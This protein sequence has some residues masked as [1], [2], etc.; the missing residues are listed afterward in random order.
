MKINVSLSSDLKNIQA[1]EQKEYGYILT[2]EIKNDELHSYF[3]LFDD[4]KFIGYIALWHDMDKAQIESIIVNAKNNGYGSYLFS[5]AMDYLKNYT[6]T[7][8]VR[9]SNSI[10][11][12]LYH[13]FGFKDVTIRKNYYSNGE[14]AILML[15]ECL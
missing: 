4:S 6:I 8:E 5:Y 1:L 7:L 12:H 10:A 3:T 9:E 11:K 14:D 15:K 13:K 2:D